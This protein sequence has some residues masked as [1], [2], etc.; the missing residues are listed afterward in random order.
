MAPIKET[1][2][3]AELSCEPGSIHETGVCK[4][5][6]TAFIKATPFKQPI[7]SDFI[8]KRLYFVNVNKIKDI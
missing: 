3:S 4:A 6:Q 7:L 5:M 1:S 8:K 2:C